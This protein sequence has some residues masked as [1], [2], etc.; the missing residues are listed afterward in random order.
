MELAREMG[1]IGK[2]KGCLYLNWNNGDYCSKLEEPLEELREDCQ[3]WVV[4]H[5]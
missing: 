3:M 2:C 1:T 5:R 4:D